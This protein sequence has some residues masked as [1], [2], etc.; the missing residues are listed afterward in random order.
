MTGHHGIEISGSDNL[1]ENFTFKTSFI[2]DLGVTKGSFGNVYSHGSGP[3]INLDH[4]KRAPYENLFTEIDAGK[5]S[6][7]WKCGGGKNLGKNSGAR[8]TFWNIKT[9]T[10][11]TVPPRNFAPD[12]INI[13][14]LKINS[15]TIK[16]PGG[17][18]IEVILPTKVIPQNLYKSQ[19]MHRLKN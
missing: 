2:H 4:H 13:I 15:E 11:I 8:E 5:G 10:G 6:R 18:W 3:D 7:L 14:G 12:L 19:L 16:S 1:C 9:S 17:K